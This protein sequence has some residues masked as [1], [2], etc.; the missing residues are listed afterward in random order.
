MNTKCLAAPHNRPAESSPYRRWLALAVCLFGLVPPAVAANQVTLADHGKT[1][2]RIVLPA[3]SIPAERYA[4]EE[5]QRYLEKISGAKLPIVADTEAPTGREIQLGNTTHLARL[6]SK[7]DFG[8]LGPDGFVLGVE[9]NTVIIAGG[10]PRGTLNGV[11]T[12]LEEELGVRWF[13]PEVELVP[14]LDRVLLPKR[15]ETRIPVLQ[16]RDVFWREMMRN[17]D[18]AARH[19][20]N[21]QHYGLTEKHGGPFT[22]YFPFVHSLDSLIPADLYQ[23]H[24]EYFPLIDGKR[25]SGYVQR[26]LSNPE[27]LKLAIAR[28]RQWIQEHPDATIISVSQNDAG[29]YCQCEQCK[30]LD[31]AEGS[32][33]ASLLKFVNAVAEAIEPDYPNIRIDT[34]AYQYTRKPP[35]TIRPRHNVIVRLCSIECCFAHPLETCPAD[36]NKRFRDDIIAWGQVAPLIYVWDY[37]TDFGHYE[38]PFPNFDALQSNVRFFVRHGVK[39]IFEQGNYSGGG[40]GE[41]GPLRAYVLAKLLWNPDTDVQQ[42]IQEFANAYYGKAAPKVLAYLD[43]THR[44]VREKGLHAH[45]Y[46]APSAPYLSPEVMD[47]AQ[48]LLDEAEQLA[49]NDDLRFR[50]QMVRLPV[51][52]T[53][54]ATD[55]VR[56]DA[57]KDLARRFVAIARKAGVSNISEGTALNDWAKAQGVE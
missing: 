1:K 8:K 56:G 21:G 43:L 16:N 53:Q 36:E 39:S 46:D 38:Q 37:T 51:W 48:K 4:A 24:P 34:L 50:V 55:R 14:K 35:K 49:D 20:L 27:V 31:D 11:Y 30:G 19:R 28:V 12:L 18:F 7:V 2:Y 45:I 40:N 25:K 6:R 3:A 52:Y 32:P 26:C 17:A 13:T 44:P 42:H 47:A 41:M 10:R 22:V 5:L 57:K 54:I 15:T 23:A 29:D 33:A 9:G